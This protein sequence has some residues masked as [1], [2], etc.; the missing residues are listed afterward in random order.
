MTRPIHTFK[1]GQQVCHHTGG[2]PGESGQ[3]LTPSSAWLGNR[4]ASSCS[5]LSAT[6]EQLAHESEL[7]LA[8][9]R[10]DIGE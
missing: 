3:P 7:K 1:I 4:A 6:H 5:R 8:L 9:S 10:K 2:L